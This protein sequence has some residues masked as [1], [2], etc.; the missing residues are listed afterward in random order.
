MMPAYPGGTV[1]A[2]VRGTRLAGRVRRT[3][4]ARTARTIRTVRSKE[5]RP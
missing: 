2:S 3:H 4:T 1:T 5:Q